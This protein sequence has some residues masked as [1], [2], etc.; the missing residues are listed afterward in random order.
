MNSKRL[1]GRNK[2]VKIKDGAVQLC[3]CEQRSRSDQQ[4]EAAGDTWPAPR[5][6]SSKSSSE[7]RPSHCRT[8]DIVNSASFYVTQPLPFFLFFQLC[9]TLC[10][11]AADSSAAGRSRRATRS[12]AGQE[13][14]AL[15]K[16]NKK[17]FSCP[18]TSPKPDWALCVPSHPPIALQHSSPSPPLLP[19]R[20]DSSGPGTAQATP[21]SLPPS[22]PTSGPTGWLIVENS[23]L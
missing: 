10:F 7:S 15:H 11:A 14:R 5:K 4:D 22:L 18:R 23:R 19:R 17:N 9:N 13:N 8:E 12:A 1:S 20:G 6:T 16:K 21:T 2:Y 3:I